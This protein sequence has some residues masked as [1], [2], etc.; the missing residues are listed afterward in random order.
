[1]KQRDRRD[2]VKEKGRK[3]RNKKGRHDK[4]EI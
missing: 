4:G 2:N 1:M 3:D